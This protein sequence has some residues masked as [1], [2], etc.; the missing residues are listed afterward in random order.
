MDSLSRMFLAVLN[1]GLP[2]EGEAVINKQDTATMKTFFTILFWP[3]RVAWNALTSFLKLVLIV[4][5][6]GLI[7]MMDS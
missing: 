6:F 5:T 2:P 3:I 4:C 7:T 1:S